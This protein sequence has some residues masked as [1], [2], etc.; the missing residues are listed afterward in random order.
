MPAFTISSLTVHRFLIT[1]LAVSSKALCDAFCTN[2]H[3]AKVGGIRVVEFNYLERE[4]LSIIDW[5][6]TVSTFILLG[7]LELNEIPVS[8][9]NSTHLLC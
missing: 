4:F 7:C 8:T 5:R 2:V 9:R 1:A 3:Y 6:L